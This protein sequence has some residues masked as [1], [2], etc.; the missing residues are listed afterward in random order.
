MKTT[1]KIVITLTLLLII[2]FC[3]ASYIGPRMIIEVNNL[4]Y[5]NRNSN[6]GVIP[7]AT[8]YQVKA[9]SIYY[10]SS[11]GLKLKALLIRSD[12][13]K[14]KGTIIMVHGIRAYKERFIPISKQ[15]NDSGYNVVMPDLRAHGESE[16]QYC[17]FGNKE[18]FDISALIDTLNTMPNIN[19]N[20]IIWGQSLGAAVSLQAMAIDKRIKLGIIESTFSDYRQI[21]HD[22]SRH[23]L[24]FEAGALIDY[25]I[26][27]SE[28]IGDFKADET[29]PAN[30]AKQINQPVLMVHGTKDKR[31]KIEYGQQNF[32]NLASQQK[33][34]IMLDG[35]NHINVWQVGGDHYFN[36][37]F[38]FIEENLDNI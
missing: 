24:G 6:K 11:D 18:K 26:W 35:A 8:D 15:I 23:T 22:Y 14:T 30:A 10:N 32:K 20:Y 34:F 38:K 29:I 2:V 19:Q 5:K 13:L 7:Q 21:V 4:V 16:G 12:S 1:H 36:T 28:N 25:F 17:T 31:I 3:F 27:L 33:R 9:E 37:V